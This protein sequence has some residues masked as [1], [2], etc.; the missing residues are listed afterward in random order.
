M[1]ILIV[2][3]KNGFHEYNKPN[4]AEACDLLIKIMNDGGTSYQLYWWEWGMK[5]RFNLQ[6]K[7]GKL[8][9]NEFNRKMMRAK[10]DFE[11]EL[12]RRARQEADNMDPSDIQIQ[13]TDTDLAPQD[14][15][16]LKADL[17]VS[18]KTINLL[19]PPKTKKDNNA[20]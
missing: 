17:A 14:L 15:D 5:E 6:T 3:K 2:E 18:V 1:Y 10:R 20:N 7:A 12:Y 11:T 13:E 4:A 19:D 16:K 9:I 8:E